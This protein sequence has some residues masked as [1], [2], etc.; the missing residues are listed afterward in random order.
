MF[1]STDQIWNDSNKQL[2]Y[3]QIVAE[4]FSLNQ[5]SNQPTNPTLLVRRVH[6]SFSLKNLLVYPE[7]VCRF[8]LIQ[9]K[10]WYHL[11]IVIKRKAVRK[12]R[13]LGRAWF[14]FIE[15]FP[16]VFL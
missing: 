8:V 9:S 1:Y 10:V 3:H 13:R 16:V 14:A 11:F 6:W 4:S 5:P 12:L 15:S 7:I 2:I